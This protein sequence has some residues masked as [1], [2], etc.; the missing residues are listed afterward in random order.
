MLGFIG[1]PP[2]HS[3]TWMRRGTLL[4]LRILARDPLQA[5]NNGCPEAD[6]RLQ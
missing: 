3:I 6:R 4:R 5:E 1:P 2:P